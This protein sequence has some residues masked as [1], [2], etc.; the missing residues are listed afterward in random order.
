MKYAVSHKFQIGVERFIKLYF[1]DA[2]ND[3]LDKEL[4]VKKRE[5]LN[6][7]HDPK[8]ILREYRVFPERKIP[9]PLNSLISKKKLSYIERREFSP[10]D[11]VLSFSVMP[12]VLKG[13]IHCSG[14]CFVH[15]EGKNSV[16][17]EIKGEIIVSVPLIGKI[18]E[19]IILKELMDS[20]ER[21]VNLTHQYYGTK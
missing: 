13:K 8:V 4:G 12:G 5:L 16:L 18:I 11:N 17:R 15:P 9:E 14:K 3:Y 20:F 7:Y 2:F 19:K 1:D 10:E 6:E 21:V